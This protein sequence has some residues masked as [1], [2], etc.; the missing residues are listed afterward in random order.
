MPKMITIERIHEP[1]AM[2]E[3]EDYQLMR[4][5]K[6]TDLTFAE[7]LDRMHNARKRKH[8]ARIRKVMEMAGRCDR[9]KV[10]A[11]ILTS[12]TPPVWSESLTW[13]QSKDIL[14]K[15]LLEASIEKFATCMPQILKIEFHI[16][17]SKDERIEFYND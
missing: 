6:Q 5:R 14:E 9:L 13:V 1:S 2:K 3:L 8:E 16:V 7:Y 15:G 4:V 17:M 12:E 10:K 11:L